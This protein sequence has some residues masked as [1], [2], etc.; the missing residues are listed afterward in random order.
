MNKHVLI[1]EF[2]PT[3]IFHNPQQQAGATYLM[4]IQAVHLGLVQCP[5]SGNRSGPT[6]EIKQGLS[7]VSQKLKSTV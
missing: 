3:I 4:H 7:V 6:V 1:I 5:L 2:L